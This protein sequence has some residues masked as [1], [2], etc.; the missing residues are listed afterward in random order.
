MSYIRAEEIL[1]TELLKELHKYVNGKCLYIPV[2]YEKR[3]DW[4]IKNGYRKELDNRDKA[5]FEL[6]QKGVSVSE[7]SKRYFLS[8]KSIYRIISKMNSIM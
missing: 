5:I 8:E 6:R 2:K 3:L 4:G 1:P 7:L